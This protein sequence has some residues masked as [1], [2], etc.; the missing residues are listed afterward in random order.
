M[1]SFLLFSNF[2]FFF[3]IFT[4]INFP[5]NSRTKEDK[6]ILIL[7]AIRCDRKDQS[8]QL[9]ESFNAI[10][11][12][13]LLVTNWQI[14]FEISKVKRT[15]KSITTFSELT[16]SYLLP[17]SITSYAIRSAL[18][19]TFR[20][21]LIDTSVLNIELI[22]KLFMDF[23]ASNF[24]QISLYLSVQSI[25]ENLLEAYFHRLYVVRRY[26][27]T[28]SSASHDVRTKNGTDYQS[29]SGN[30][31]DSLGSTT[32]SDNVTASI[33]YNSTNSGQK[34]NDSTQSEHKGSS[35]TNGINDST[36]RKHPF[37]SSF[38]VEALKILTR[39]YLSSLKAYTVEFEIKTKE[40]STYVKY[41][42][43][44]RENFNRVYAHHISQNTNCD[45]K[46][47][48]L[49][50]TKFFTDSSNEMKS[51]QHSIQLIKIP[52]LF[53]LQRPSYLNSMPPIGD[54]NSM[55]SGANG[56]DTG[57]ETSEKGRKAIGVVLKL[58]V[59]YFLGKI[60]IELFC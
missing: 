54:F 7:D 10:D 17:A 49:D 56:K 43:F 59:R 20:N 51:E 39:I 38:N 36:G 25:L 12:H 58:Q 1:F 31:N 33:G 45:G 47:L 18:L 32:S 9:L 60:F 3:N 5:F 14:L 11:L 13:R 16:E 37:S 50:E 35:N 28:L 52:I 21:L 26:S 42:K 2:L 44:L 34:M 29:K 55:E 4:Q 41:V 8:M 22:L 19:A 40:K 15:G 46:S 53:L 48:T 6:L 24:G 27:D 57:F 30:N 23:L